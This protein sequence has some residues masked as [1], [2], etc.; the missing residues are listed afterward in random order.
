MENHPYPSFPHFCIAYVNKSATAVMII[1]ANARSGGWLE[2]KVGADH[3]M[4]SQN[5]H[6]EM[7]F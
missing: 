2:D 3:Q 5:V 4:S 7:S 1:L 6:S